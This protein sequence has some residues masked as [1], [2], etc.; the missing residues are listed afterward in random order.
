MKLISAAASGKWSRIKL[1][2][3][4]LHSAETQKILQSSN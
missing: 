2:A 1:S 3:R 4:A